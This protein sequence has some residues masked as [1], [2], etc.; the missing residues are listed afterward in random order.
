MLSSTKAKVAVLLVLMIL[1]LL[2]FGTEQLDNNYLISVA[3][4]F[5]IYAIAAVSLDL[6][7]GYGAL[8]SFGHAMFFAIGGYS[9]AIIAHHHSMMEPIFFWEGS[10]QALILWPIALLICAVLGAIVGL[11]ALR[12]RGV[13]FIMVTLAFAQLLYF[14]LVSL[15]PYGG[16][17]GLFMYEPNTLPLIDLED[18]VQFYYV[19]L[20]ALVLWVSFCV[21]IVRSK[22]GMVLQAIRQSERRVKNLGASPKSYQLVA[23]IWSAVGT[24]LA[25][26]LWANYAG[27]VT[28]DMASW[29]KSGEFLAMVV[30]GGL[31]TLFGA[32]GGVIVFLGLERVLATWTEH[33]ML[34]MGP[35][36]VLVALYA[37]QGLFGRF[38]G[39]RYGRE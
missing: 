4:R 12:T 37:K 27:L 34:V 5:L 29:M 14:V 35:V 36:L 30:L 22:F 39:G 32:I 26:I 31:G 16:D 19:C 33:W 25:G 24:G 20:V 1:A 10:N 3:T 8:V 18:K 6:I 21:L 7:L 13:Q 23:F 9:V 17:E 28:P 2:P 38:F 15:Q 11:F